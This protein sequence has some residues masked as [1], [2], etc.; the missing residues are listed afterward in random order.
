MTSQ[1][2]RPRSELKAEAEIIVGRIVLILSQLELNIGLLLRHLATGANADAVN[3]LVD[4]LTFKNKLD[5]ARE[6][7]EHR[8]A[9]NSECLVEFI[10]WHARADKLRVKRNS[11]MHGRWGFS[12]G[13]AQIVNVSPGMP[14]SKPQREKRY[15]VTS[16]RDEAVEAEA[17]SDMFH[18]WTDRWT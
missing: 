9:A 2:I 16:L 6:I 10:T 13:P 4:R 18:R 7:L 17:V 1:P 14:S 8:Y 5:A 3:P 12:A 11:F 15:T